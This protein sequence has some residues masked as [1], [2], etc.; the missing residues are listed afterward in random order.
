MP[1]TLAPAPSSRRSGVNE[2]ATPIAVIRQT[3][4]VKPLMMV[5]MSG[6]KPAIQVTTIGGA[7]ARGPGSAAGL[8]RFAGR[9]TSAW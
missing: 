7:D 3:I 2:K 4:Q 9:A 1:I 6:S 5:P 8:P